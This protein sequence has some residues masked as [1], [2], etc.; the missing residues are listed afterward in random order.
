MPSRSASV[1]FR[2]GKICPMGLGRASLGI[3]ALVVGALVALT[4]SAL[5]DT[6]LYIHGAGA[7]DI[8]LEEVLRR[9]PPGYDYQEVDYPAGMWP[10]NGFHKMTGAQSIAIGV[11]NLD[12]AIRATMAKDPG[13]VLVIGESL[14]SMVVDEELR[15]LAAHADFTD[16]ARLRFELIAAPARTDGY[17]SYRPVGN[18][19]LLTGTR[20]QALPVTPYDITVLKLQYDGVASWP[21][22]PWRLLSD[23]HALAGAFLYH[24][25]DHYGLAAQAFNN[26]KP[27]AHTTTT[28][29]NA[30]GGTTTTYTVAQQSALAHILQPIFPNSVEP[31]DKII[32]AV[33]NR[34][35]SQLTPN[36]GPHLDFGAVRVPRATASARSS[37][38]SSPRAAAG[39]SARR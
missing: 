15:Q 9:I 14:G 30:L 24:G 31:L 27:P 23:A 19:I 4:P 35:Y 2:S 26:G 5:A 20:L 22:R 28:T 25:T 10:W 11:P 8:P 18:R 36:A 16:P 34:G 29:V 13:Q 32:S 33:V 1:K 6:A 7:G 3:A 21:D 37:G 17:F 12:A 38:S 39:T